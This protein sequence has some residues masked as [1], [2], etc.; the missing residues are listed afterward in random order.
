MAGGGIVEELALCLSDPV[1]PPRL[2]RFDQ[3][4]PP[5]YPA[6]WIHVSFM[7]L[8]AVITA[9]RDKLTP[10]LPLSPCC[11]TTWSGVCYKLLVA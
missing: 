1:C 9:P 2:P 6:D 10:A 5:T 4:H 8:L 3:G 7:R 11:V